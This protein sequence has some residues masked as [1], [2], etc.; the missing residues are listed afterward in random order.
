M[1]SADNWP[2]DKRK[3][4]GHDSG[5]IHNNTWFFG[6]STTSNKESVAVGFIS[7]CHQLW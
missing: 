1:K 4:A 5:L 3:E 7:A 6:W 2:V